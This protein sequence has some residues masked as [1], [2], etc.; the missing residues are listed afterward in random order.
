MHLYAAHYGNVQNPQGAP[1]LILHGLFGS[2]RNWHPVA[3][4]LSEQNSVFSLDLRNHGK[5]PHSDVMD[6]PHMALDVVQFIEQQQLGPVRIIAH[7]MGG[8]VAMWLALTR[9]ELVQKLVVVD[10]APVSYEHDFSDVIRAFRVVPLQSI[11][12]RKDADQAM[13]TVITQT[14]L[15]QFLLQNLQSRNGQ[16]CWRL[17]LDIL[18]RSMADITGFPDTDRV[19]PYDKRVLFVGGGLSDYISKDNQKLTRK[20]FPVASFSQ[21]KNAGHWLHAE[22]PDL[23]LSLIS[24]YLVS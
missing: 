24:H 23:F 5:S 7:S 11:D 1:I 20:L 2:H 12:S 3:R 8:K 22:Q 6:Y 13:A 18:E 9:P 14:E 16:Y 15:R 4:T 10:I 21:I 19:L 17:N